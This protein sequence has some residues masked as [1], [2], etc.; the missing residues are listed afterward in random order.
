MTELLLKR[1]FNEYLLHAPF[2]AEKALL[3]ATAPSP[4]RLAQNNSSWRREELALV[5]MEIDV[6][7]ISQTNVSD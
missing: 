3:L 2:A 7:E 4:I 5:R 1:A 6:S